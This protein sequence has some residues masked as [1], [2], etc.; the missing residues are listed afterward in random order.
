MKDFDPDFS[1][2]TLKANSSGS[3][4][5]VASFHAE[6]EHKVKDACLVLRSVAAKRATKFKL[7]DALGGTLETLGGGYPVEWKKATS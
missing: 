1:I 6:D 4:C 3:W 5:T 2:V 7:C